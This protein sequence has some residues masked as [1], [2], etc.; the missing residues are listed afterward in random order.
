MALTCR[1]LCALCCTWSL[2]GAA[3]LPEWK[4]DYMPDGDA[5]K[6]TK[7][8]LR[9]SNNAEPETLDPQ[10]MT[11]VTESRIA[12]ALY[13]GLVTNDPADLSIRPGVAKSWTISDDGL[14]YTFT[15]RDDAKWSD[16]K[17]IT[18]TDFVVSWKRLL[19]KETAAEYAYQIFPVKNA[20]AYLAGTVTDFAD[21]GVK[22]IDALTLQVTLHQPCPYFLDLCAF[23][24]LAPVRVDIIENFGDTWTRPDHLVCNGPFIMETWKQRE[25]IVLKKNPHYWDHDFVKLDMITIL[26][27]DDMETSYQL[28]LKG[29]LDWIKAVPQ[30][31][32]DEVRQHPDYYVEPYLGSYFYRF[33]CTRPPFTGENG[34]LVRQAMSLAVNREHITKHITKAGQKPATFFCPP[35]AGYQ[36]VQGLAYNPKKAQALL[37]QAGY[38]DGKGFPDVELMFNTSEAHKQIAEAI[39]QQWKDI[40]GISIKLR[41]KEW[42]MYLQDMSNLEYDMMRSSWIG[43]YNDPNTYFDMFIKDGGNNRT[44][45][46]NETYDALLKESQSEADHSKRLAIF[47]KME[48]ILVE[49]ELPIMPIYMYVYQGMINESIYGFE[50]NIRDVHPYQYMWLEE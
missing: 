26:P 44:G 3:D 1:L 41:N 15:L 23:T 33:N 22:A 30:L 48:R 39:C 45:W 14:V 27:Y 5:W 17:N 21:V 25:A 29:E 50:H 10:L 16:G 19:Q 8:H 37:A 31:R 24:T 2:L 7:Q 11:G 38:P 43:D 6:A 47:Q 34:K 32:I 4:Q 13:E 35:T 20:E 28:Y 42:K 49:D 40:L 9:M 46:S 36:P 18:S 12:L